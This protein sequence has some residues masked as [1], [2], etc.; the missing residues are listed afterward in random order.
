MPKACSGKPLW[1]MN[2]DLRYC[3]HKDAKGGGYLNICRLWR[4]YRIRH[5][6]WY[7]QLLELRT[8]TCV[9][10]FS[11][12]ICL[13]LKIAVLAIGVKVAP[14]LV[15]RSVRR[16]SGPII[17]LHRCTALSSLRRLS[18]W[19]SPCIQPIAFLPLLS[20]WLHREKNRTLFIAFYT[21]RL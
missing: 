2:W 20:A 12:M 19:T 13:L 9:C 21:V 5:W 16:W 6:F 1:R 4:H 18:G 11:V 15:S 8:I 17:H 14:L 3:W 10:K 7:A